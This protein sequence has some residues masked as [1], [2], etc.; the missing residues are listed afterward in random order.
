MAAVGHGK[1]GSEVLDVTKKGW[2]GD[3]SEREW[4]MKVEWMTAAYI[5]Q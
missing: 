4:K 5:C 2:I 3:W 1:R